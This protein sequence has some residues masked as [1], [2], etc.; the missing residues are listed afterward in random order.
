MKLVIIGIPDS[1]SD[2]KTPK[3]DDRINEK[4]GAKTIASFLVNVINN[5]QV[6]GRIVSRSY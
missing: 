4:K 5:V 3:T 2:R 1:N 6:E